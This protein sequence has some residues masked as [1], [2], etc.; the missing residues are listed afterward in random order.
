VAPLQYHAW[1]EFGNRLVNVV[2]TLAI[3]ASAL[4]TLRR[5]PRR[6][7]LVLLSSALVG[8]ILAEVVLG[9][10]TVLHKLAPPY[11]MGHMLLA[12]LLLGTAVVFYYR[13]GEPED[14]RED[15]PGELPRKTLTLP[16]TWRA[17]WAQR[18]AATAMLVVTGAVITLGTVVT[19]TG[20]HAGAPGVPRFG[21]SLHT[22]AQLHGTSVEVLLTITVVTLWR[23]HRTRAPRAVLKRAEVLL[24]VLIAQAAVGYTQYFTGDPALLVGFHLAGA[25]SVVVA[26]VAFYMSL[27]AREPHPQVQTVSEVRQGPRALIKA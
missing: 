5:R 4:S 10:E 27:Y 14:V 25:T 2:I 3:V 11:V 21:F 19:G 12:L 9:G 13:A 6:R 22:V 8:G 17:S 23:L 18:V 26:M 1:V 16:P 20:P 24:V 7:D 15:V